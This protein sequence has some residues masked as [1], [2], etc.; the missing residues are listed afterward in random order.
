MRHWVAPSCAAGV[1][2]DPGLLTSFFTFVYSCTRS[3]ATMFV[4]SSEDVRTNQFSV[5]VTCTAEPQGAELS[6][7]QE[8]PPPTSAQALSLGTS[9]RG[10]APNSPVPSPSKALLQHL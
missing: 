3:T 5:W 9:I 2:L 6:G 8:H 7:T 4:S 1:C 10:P